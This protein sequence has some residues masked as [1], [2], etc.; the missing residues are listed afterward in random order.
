MT[1]N[2]SCQA[3]CSEWNQFGNQAISILDDVMILFFTS[4]GV[5][6]GIAVVVLSFIRRERM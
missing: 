5:I 4:I 3:R 6:A 1:I 2:N